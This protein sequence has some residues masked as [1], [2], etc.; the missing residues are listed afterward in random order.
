MS[1][2]KVSRN[3]I[4]IA[5]EFY[6]AH[7]LTKHGFK[8]SPTLGRTEV[9]DLF[10]Q[11]PTGTNINISVKTTYLKVNKFILMNKK[12][13]K[14]IN[15]YLFYAFVRLNMPDGI[16]EFWIVPSKVVAPV[17][18][19]EHIIWMKETAKN[20]TPHQENP[21]RNFYLEA[22]YNFPDDWEEQLESFKS[23]VKSLEELK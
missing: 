4:S 23:N 10:A 20:G 2:L 13:E 1:K 22:H 11:N 8:V 9:F 12:A 21:L 6:I 7:V 17:L 19:K 18:E 16:P 15:D 3:D 14:L 5:G